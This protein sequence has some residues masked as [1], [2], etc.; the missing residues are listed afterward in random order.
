L[1]IH[2]K[3]PVAVHTQEELSNTF[4]FRTALSAF[5]LALDWISVGGPKDVKITKIRNDIVDVSFAAY[6]TYFDG[7][8]SM[9]EKLVRIYH[10]AAFVLDAITNGPGSR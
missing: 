10:R 7:V 8:L 6:A 5:F 3:P 1:E 9:D 2:P 4:L